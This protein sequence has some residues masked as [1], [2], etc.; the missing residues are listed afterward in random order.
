MISKYF[1]LA[2]KK[3]Q[4]DQ[5]TSLKEKNEPHKRPGAPKEDKFKMNV[6]YENM[7]FFIKLHI[8]YI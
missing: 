4:E 1:N 5:K 6:K 7:N 8:K 2:K 3:R